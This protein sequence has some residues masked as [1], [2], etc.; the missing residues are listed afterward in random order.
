MKKVYPYVIRSDEQFTLEQIPIPVTEEV[1]DFFYKYKRSV[2]N[3]YIGEIHTKHLLL[4]DSGSLLKAIE[5]Y[6]NK[7]QY[8]EENISDDFSKR[9]FPKI[10]WLASTSIDAE[11]K[12]PIAV[13]YNP[14]QEQN[15]IHP[16]SIRNHILKLFRPTSMVKSLY[17]N[18]GG[19]EFEFMKTMTIVDKESL[20]SYKDKMHMY[21]VADHCSIIPHINLDAYSVRPSI[22]KWQK[23]LHLRLTSPTFT[24]FCNTN[25]KMLTPWTTLENDANIHIT[26][27]SPGPGETTEDLL[28]KSIILAILGK[29]YYSESLTVTHKNSFEFPNFIGEL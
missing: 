10:C 7:K 24:I 29:P 17:F 2:E 23:Y 1:V 28:C 19:V 25:I 4:K 13:H 5:I 27:G 20:L 6:F 3:L 12:H 18:T 11:L 22:Q 8:L 14:R 9:L 21:L 16:G 15:V 26:I